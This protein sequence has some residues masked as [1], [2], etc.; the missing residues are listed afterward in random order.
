MKAEHNSKY[1]FVTRSAFA[2]CDS[3]SPENLT[4]IESAKL[5][6]AAVAARG[7]AALA[8]AG[9]ESFLLSWQKVL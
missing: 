4:F 2:S 7:A 5:K 3:D 1:V 9:R 6:E 8:L